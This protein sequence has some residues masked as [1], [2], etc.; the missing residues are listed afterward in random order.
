VVKAKICGITR[1]EDALLAE[2][3]GAWA[4]GFILVPASRRY[5]P[6]EHYAPISRALGPFIARVGVFQDAPPEAVLE[7]MRA[8]HLQVVQLHGDEPPEWAEALRPHYPVIKAF[9]LSGPADPRLADYP[10][11]ALMLD[12]TNPGSGEGYPLEWLEPLRHH[13][14]LIVAGGLNPENLGPVLALKPYAV[15]VSSGVEEAPGVKS[16]DKL[17]AFLRAV[18]NSRSIVEAC[19]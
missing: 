6:P 13:P 5:R 15:D 9:K 12:G 16:P 7:A 4:V 10:A 3:W 11:D 18:D 14:R 8:A 2:Q 1:L 19:G 17:R